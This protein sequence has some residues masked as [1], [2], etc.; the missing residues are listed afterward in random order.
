MIGDAH[1]VEPLSQALQDDN[2]WFQEV[3]VRALGKRGKPALKPLMEIVDSPWG[4]D[5]YVRA[6]AV[7]AVGEIG[8]VKAI[9]PLLTALGDKD[10]LI[11]S[12]AA[13]A[14]VKI[15]DLTR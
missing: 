8:D 12:K 11:R 7:E 6:A 13:K 2:T 10:S 3:V 5:P 15:D 14:L 9:F 1:A 4:W